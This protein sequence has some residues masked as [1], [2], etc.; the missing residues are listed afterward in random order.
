MTGGL[1]INQSN[2]SNKGIDMTG[3]D[4]YGQSHPIESPELISSKL[5]ELELELDKLPEAS[6]QGWEQAKQKCPKML[7]KDFKLSFLRC[8]VF[9][10]DVSYISSTP[11]LF[12]IIMTDP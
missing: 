6:K 8:E 10:S 11:L 3:P 5:A 1:W 4:D 12:K 2:M 7:D 9:N